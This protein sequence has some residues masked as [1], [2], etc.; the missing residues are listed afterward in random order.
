MWLCGASCHPCELM[1]SYTWTPGWLHRHCL[2]LAP[3]IS[4]QSLKH[5]WFLRRHTMY[6][7][8]KLYINQ[9]LESLCM[10]WLQILAPNSDLWRPCQCNHDFFLRNIVIFTTKMDT[11]WNRLAILVDFCL[12]VFQSSHIARRLARGSQNWVGTFFL[13]QPMDHKPGLGM[14][15]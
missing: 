10:C 14:M 3:E 2:K 15:T 13:W 6:Y 1:D 7:L 11:I 9:I 4:E 8:S 5:G 12:A